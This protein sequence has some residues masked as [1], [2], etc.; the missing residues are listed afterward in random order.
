MSE[1]TPQQTPNASRALDAGALWH[2]VARSLAMPCRGRIAIGFFFVAGG[3]LSFG[4]Q[5]MIW[6]LFA[7][8]LDLVLGYAG[9]VTLGHA[10]YFG[11]GAY[12]AGLYFD[13]R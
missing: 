1:Q 4:T 5:I 3:Y 2:A 7:M 13:P 9:I 11:F 12:V 6:I 10:A 8:S